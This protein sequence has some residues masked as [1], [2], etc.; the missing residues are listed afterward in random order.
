VTLSSFRSV[1]PARSFGSARTWALIGFVLA[2][3]APLGLWAYFTFVGIS[4]SD[5]V[6]R[7]ALIYSAV[8]TALVFTSFG[9]GV[10]SLMDRLRSAAL[11][12]GLTGLFNRR[13]LRESLPQLQASANRRGA[14]LCLIMLDLDLFKRVNDNYGHLIGDQTLRAVSE[15][16]RESSR[17]SDVVARYGGEE[18]A[19]LCPDTDCE[20]G[21]Y[22][23]ER[24]RAAVEALD[25][26]QLGHP[27]PQTISLGVAVQAHD[28]E[29][30]PEQLIEHA[31]VAMYEAKHRG[32]NRA[33]AWLDGQEYV[34]DE[35]AATVA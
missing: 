19:V 8:M 1:G 30:T 28:H 34:R 15:A 5:E 22:V 29:L 13:F 18:F 27:G 33:I 20:T 31:D 16:L 35:K 2:P 14:P 21:L 17:R 32:R 23:A 6:A 10:G 26:T 3:G 11:H 7:T 25:Q 4:S 12:D 24:L 9:F